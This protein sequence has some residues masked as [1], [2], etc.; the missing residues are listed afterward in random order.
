ML[1]IEQL[2]TLSQNNLAS[3]IK[4]AKLSLKT[5]E[6]EDDLGFLGETNTTDPTMQLTFDILK[7]IYLTKKSEAE[8]IRDAATIKAH[9]QK[10]LGLIAEKQE[11]GLKGMSIAELEAQLK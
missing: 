3:A 9:N 7:D 10:I 5:T 6:G 4:E 2:W 11:E 1:S 8:A